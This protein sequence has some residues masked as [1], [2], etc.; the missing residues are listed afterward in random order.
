MNDEN[1]DREL[2]TEA[3]MD[4][5]KKAYEILG[6]HFEAFTLLTLGTEESEKR[7][8]TKVTYKGGYFISQGMIFEALRKS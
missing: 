4:A 8:G 3:Q 6:E 1:E 2:H 5:I 7:E